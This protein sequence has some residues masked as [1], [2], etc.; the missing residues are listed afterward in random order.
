[1]ST[2]ALLVAPGK[3]VGFLLLANASAIS[4]APSVSDCIF[5]GVPT[6]TSLYSHELGTFVQEMKNTEYQCSIEKDG[7]NIVIKV[8][9]ST[10]SVVLLTVKS[11]GV[12]KWHIEQKGKSSVEGICELASKKG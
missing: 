10:D 9:T 5:T 1:M 3:L 4:D 12:G 11:D 2:I 8:T 7:T 6:E